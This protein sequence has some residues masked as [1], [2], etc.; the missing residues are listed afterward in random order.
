MVS[1][2]FFQKY[3]GDAII[4]DVWLRIFDTNGN[5]GGF[6]GR[7]N[8]PPHIPSIQYRQEKIRSKRT[9]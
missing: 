9:I 5:P 7:T 8:T 2:D 6:S 3:V 4:F 1:F